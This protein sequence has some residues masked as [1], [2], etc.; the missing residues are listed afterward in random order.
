MFSV[1]MPVWNKRPFLAQAMAGL[2]SQ[3]WREFELIAVDD[4]ST[5]GS[6]DL[7]RGFDDPRIRIFTQPNAGPGPA[8]N[9]GLE[10]ARHDWI[11][12][13]DAD[14]LWLPDHLAELDRIRGAHPEAGLIGTRF[15][16]CGRDGMFKMPS[17]NQSRIAEIDYFEAKHPICTSSSGIP[18]HVYRCLG[19]FS[20]AV[21]GQDSEYMA[22]IAL[23]HVVAVS[24]RA[25]IAYRVGTGGISDAPT[26]PWQG[27]A[28]R[29][30][31][32]VE[33]SL[34]LLLARLPE[35]DCARK[36]SAI[37]LYIDR[38][39][40]WCVRKAAR[41]GDVATL[42]ALPPLF[43]VPPS[44]Q[45]RLILA[46]ARLPAPLARSAYRIGLA[47]KRAGRRLVRRKSF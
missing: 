25:T 18:R 14:D 19:G 10:A 12:F 39:L 7:L 4:G 31:A 24:A 23:Q 5:D 42:R 9:R 27:K 28:I 8:R 40:Q 13:H 17:P 41:T 47:S 44:L 11:A 2:L 45:D 22:R 34:A 1:V 16:I 35:I 43:S 37:P 36:R 21:P 26:S 46:L 3:T 29:S 20:D 15:V 30:A 32:D 6:L 38:K 33:P